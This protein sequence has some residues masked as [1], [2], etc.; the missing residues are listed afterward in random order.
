MFE[1]RLLSFKYAFQGLF[2]LIRT[3]PN[4]K[5][6]C[7][8]ALVALALSFYFQ[9]SSIEW[10]LIIFAIT[11]VLSAEAF[12][13]AIE[14]L[15]DLVSPDYHPLAGKAKDVAAGAVLCTAIGAFVVGLIIFAPKFF[16]LFNL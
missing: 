6:H 5:I 9:L 3:Q 12:N 8:A 13:T 11:S 4:A 16:A 14:Y 15:T 1:K 10:C 2:T 7:F